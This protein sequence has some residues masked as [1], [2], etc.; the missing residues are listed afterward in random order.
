MRLSRLQVE[1]TSS[2][3]DGSDGRGYFFTGLQPVQDLKI[4]I[5]TFLS[6]GENEHAHGSHLRDPSIDT[7][8]DMEERPKNIGGRCVQL[9]L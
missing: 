6:F 7:V 8:A 5:S 1:R 2:L 9:C 3:S 4:T